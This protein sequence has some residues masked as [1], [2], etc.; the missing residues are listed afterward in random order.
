[1]HHNIPL[2]Y[3][4]LYFQRWNEISVVVVVYVNAKVHDYFVDILFVMR[5][6]RLLNHDCIC[7]A[8]SKKMEYI[9]TVL[10]LLY[11]LLACPQFSSRSAERRK[12]LYSGPGWSTI[13]DKR[14]LLHFEVKRTPFKAQI[15]YEVLSKRLP[16]VQRTMWHC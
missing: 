6:N 12:L 8:E 2:T 15:L 7:T 5:A 4:L 16:V 13:I 1:V 10:S 9:S 11:P 3:L 14:V